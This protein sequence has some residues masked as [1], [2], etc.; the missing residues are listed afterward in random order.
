MQIG[1]PV[2]TII[3]TCGAV[4]ALI[5]PSPVPVFL[6]VNAVRNHL[7]ARQGVALYFGTLALLG[8]IF[9]GFRL[10]LE[11]KRSRGQS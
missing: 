11:R 10:L 3:W 1:K 4:L 5:V 2:M 7:S 6:W 9:Y 8:W